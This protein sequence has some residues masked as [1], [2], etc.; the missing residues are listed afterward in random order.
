MA[1]IIEAVAKAAEPKKAR[2]GRPKKNVTKIPVEVHG[3]V[4]EP[5]D[6]DDYL[7]MVYCNPVMFKKILQLYKT[8]QVSDV[9]MRFDAAGLKMVTKDHLGKSTIYTMIDGRCMNLY[10]CRM[11]MR[12]TVKRDDLESVLGS[13]SKSHYKITFILDKDFRSKLHLTIK[14]LEYDNEDT[15][16]IDVIYKEEMAAADQRDD[17]SDYPIKFCISSK[18]F[19]TKINHI[20][21]LSKTFSVQKVGTEPLQF[22]FDKAQKVP[23]T[24]VYNNDEKIALKST[25]AEGDIF[26]VSVCIDHIKPF[27]NAN[28]GDSVYICADKLKKMSFM[29]QLD[30]KDDVGWAATVKIYTEITTMPAN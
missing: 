28:I 10:Y 19:K 26:N 21:K 30:H 14:D 24:G 1:D 11:P 8:F 20:R 27:S 22:T 5:A 18:H 16:S 23:W 15:Y 4:D 9:E 13:L 29:T 3:I 2:V 12:I 7:E 6:A 17:D 25:I